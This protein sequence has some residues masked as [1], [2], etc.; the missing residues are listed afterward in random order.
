MRRLLLAA[1]I[2]LPAAPVSAQPAASSWQGQ[3]QNEDRSRLAGLWRSWT[4]SLAELTAA[5]GGKEALAD[6][7]P[8][9]VPP[10]EPLPG[11]D[12]AITNGT[13]PAIGTYSCRTLRLGQR[14]DGW[15]R[16]GV[17]PLQI[18]AWGACTIAA[19]GRQ[20]LYFAM[21][22]GPQRF[23]GQLWPDGDR[24]V[25]LGALSLAAEVGIRGY[26]DD[27]DRDHLGILRPLAPGHWRLELPW[28][29]WQSNLML[30]EIRAE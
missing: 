30:I 15:P 9:G 25:F 12:A 8:V 24:M 17:L 28:P 18:G 3:I 2:A 20:P 23:T 11:R 4:R 7:G 19:T 10:I 26:G 21:A 22:E 13:L 1:L 6:L 27:P 5:P 16:D 14:D 29:R